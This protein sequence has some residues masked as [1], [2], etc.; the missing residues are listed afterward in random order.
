MGRLRRIR[1]EEDRGGGSAYFACLLIYLSVSTLPETDPSTRD[2]GERGEGD[3]MSS[4]S[5]QLMSLP[6]KVDLR[7]SLLRD[8]DS[9]SLRE[10]GLEG[11]GYSRMT[12]R[13]RRGGSEGMSSTFPF[14]PSL[15]LLLLQRPQQTCQLRL[16]F[17]I[18]SQ[19]FG[20][21]CPHRIDLQVCESWSISWR[22]HSRKETSS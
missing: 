11:S 12:D 19:L 7:R 5:S 13:G 21:P 20:S 3:V 22:G 18:P 10:D 4:S 17:H 6:G 9:S 8:L 16:R 2:E 1:S 14:L 15:L